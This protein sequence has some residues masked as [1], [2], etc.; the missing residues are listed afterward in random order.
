MGFRSTPTPFLK[1]PPGGIGVISI[2]FFNA[3]CGA[4]DARAIVF[5]GE[6]TVDGFA[7]G[8]N[9]ANGALL[10]TA[11]Q[12]YMRSHMAGVA[13]WLQVRRV[14]H[15][16]AAVFGCRAVFHGRDVVH[17]SGKRF[18][19][20]VHAAHTQRTDAQHLCAEF[21]PSGGVDHGAIVRA[22]I[23]VH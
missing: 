11:S 8:L 2:C 5:A 9:T 14:E 4:L 21:H 13:Q 15:Q 7:F 18:A 1:H 6:E 23:G 3:W 19:P 12:L 17:F 10:P 16:T 22:V 20:L